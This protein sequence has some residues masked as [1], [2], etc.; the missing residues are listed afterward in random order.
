MKIAVLQSIYKPDYRG[1]VEVVVENIVRGLKHSGHDVFVIAVGRSNKSEEVDGIKVHR[2]KSFNF[3]NFL[4]INRQ[5]AWKRL[6][7]HVL[8]LANDFQTWRIFRILS[9][10]RP[11]LILTHNLKGLGY[12]APLLAKILGI[13]HVHTIHDMQLIHPSGLYLDGQKMSWPEKAYC[14]ICRIV[15]GSPDK[16]VFPSQHIKETY[17]RL[18]F[19][20]QSLKAVL[21]NPLPAEV[22]IRQA[23]K[24]GK[25][26]GLVFAFVGQ[27]EG[28][29]GIIG[30]IK[31]L[32]GLSGNWSLLVAGE[33]K[34]LEEAKKLSLDLP[35]VKFF[36]RLSQIELE[37]KIWSEADLLINPSQVAESFGMVVIEAYARG[38]PVLASSIGA[39]A[40]IVKDGET[41]WLFKSED[42]YDLRHRL[43]FVLEN[44]DKAKELRPNCLR[45]AEK[46]LMPN[47]LRELF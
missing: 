41:G 20:P 47:Y 44:R 43:E 37:Q 31:A 18:N 30:L 39:L 2:V 7:W 29:K 36:G 5:P 32:Q 17:S 35:Q 10:E 16:V 21:G 23:K 1:G 42:W 22:K 6:F 26:D 46:Y 33:G 27:V 11:D 19:F 3:F 9:S 13:R 40:E 25:K 24:G 4:D 12:G 38:I 8:D 34:A 14:L 15:F 28:Y 45:A